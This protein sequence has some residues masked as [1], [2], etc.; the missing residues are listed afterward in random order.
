MR[1]AGEDWLVPRRTSRDGSA[2]SDRLSDG[3]RS[4]EASVEPIARLRKYVHAGGHC[5]TRTLLPVANENL[6]SL[7][8]IPV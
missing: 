2:I 7:I 1:R 6:R 5:S 8:T 3:F 4:T